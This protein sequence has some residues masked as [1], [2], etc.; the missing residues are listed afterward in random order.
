MEH[1]SNAYAMK[2][3][4]LRI[5]AFTRRN[6]NENSVASEPVVQSMII[7]IAAASQFMTK[8][9]L[10]AAQLNGDVVSLMTIYF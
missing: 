5:W 2:N 7:L 10:F 6:V 4:K 9:Q 8:R 1:A 3:L